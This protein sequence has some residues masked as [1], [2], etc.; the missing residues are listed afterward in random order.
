MAPLE[1]DHCLDD[2]TVAV[3]IKLNH[4][5]L[6]SALVGAPQLIV[7]HLLQLVLHL[8]LNYM[9]QAFVKRG[10]QLVGQKL[11]RVPQLGLQIT[12]LLFSL[13][14]LALLNIDQQLKGIDEYYRRSYDNIGCCASSPKSRRFV[15]PES[16]TGYENIQT[17]LSVFKPHL[18]FDMLLYRCLQLGLFFVKATIQVV[19]ERDL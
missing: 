15:A 2:G 10:V 7:A 6:D 4:L 3:Q 9:L 14:D 17:G 11:L 18:P 12:L 1:G 5:V 16:N 13:F 19:D 8:P